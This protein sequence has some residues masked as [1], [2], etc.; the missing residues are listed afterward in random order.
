MTSGYTAF[1]AASAGAAAAFI[2]L[3]FVAL[4]F[5]DSEDASER[6]RSWRR[7]MASSAY[8]QLTNV[9]FVSLVGLTPGIRSA[10][11][12]ACVFGVLGL[13]VAI[14]LLPKTIDIN[15]SGRTRPSVL[16][17]IAVAAYVIE[18]VA[19][20]DLALNSSGSNA[21]GYLVVAM[22]ILYAGALARAWE[23]AGIKRH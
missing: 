20:F 3:L 12:T 13:F 15:H 11:I 17:L 10:A 19:G 8:A 23:I 16:G 4:S 7:I 18:L 21:M 6:D 1:F 2:G 22:C 14:Q 5:I 9:F